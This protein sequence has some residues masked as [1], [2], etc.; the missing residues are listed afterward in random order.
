MYYKS[1]TIIT[2]ILEIFTVICEKG[3]VYKKR[4]REKLLKLRK[5]QVAAR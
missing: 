3:L 2:G 5:M 1:Y 4:E